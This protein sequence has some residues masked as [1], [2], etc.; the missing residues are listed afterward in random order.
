M[1]I[2]AVDVG[3]S[4]VKAGVFK[5]GRFRNFS[6]VPVASQMHGA[7]VEI[8]AGGL[9]KAVEEAIR[10]AA[11]G[12][13][14]MDALALDT[15]C[16][17]VVTLD[18]QRQPLAGCITHQDRRSVPQSHEIEEA[19]GRENHLRIAGNRPFPG[20]IAST[21]LLWLR[22]NQPASWKRTAF[23]GQ[24]SSLI[25]YHLTGR[26]VIDPSQA[27]FLGLYDITRGDWSAELCD[28]IGVKPAQLPELAPADQ[29]LGKLSAGA[30]RRLGLP[31]DMPVIGGL[32]DTSAAMLATELHAG[33]LVHSA[34]SSDVLALCVSAARPADDLLTRPLGV[35]IVFPRR[36][37]AVSTI[38][39]GGSSIRWAFENFFRDMK[40]KKFRELISKFATEAAD[41]A[42]RPA[43][44]GERAGKKSAASH[45]P[46]PDSNAP[47]FQ[48][49]LA[50][51]RTSMEQHR[52]AFENLTLSTTREDMLRAIVH[53]L[54]ASSTARFQ[55]LEKLHPV[56]KTVYTMGGQEELASAMHRAWPG[57]HTFQPIEH[58]AL[59]GLARLAEKVLKKRGQ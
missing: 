18:K 49:Y 14:R 21:S 41:H 9:L 52:G 30:A 57:R 45:A 56:Q 38:A 26:W 8:P 59:S 32:V 29:I 1:R 28:C 12:H 11:D 23:I 20:V 43:A 34:G 7:E 47:I 44:A 35:E 50:G 46:S 39:A 25:I 5:G 42:R 58:E 51:D 13:R 17:G 54:V 33:Q 36:T 48:P 16:P 55:R 6:H 3:S 10:I 40:H 15:F 37:L 27:A 24:A 22:Q 2:I 4:S 31:A 53:A 19:I